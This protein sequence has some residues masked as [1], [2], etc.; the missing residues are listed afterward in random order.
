MGSA[1][2]WGLLGGGVCWAGVCWVVG[3]AGWLGSGPLVPVILPCLR[4]SPLDKDSFV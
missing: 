3:S 4:T 1:E 2:W